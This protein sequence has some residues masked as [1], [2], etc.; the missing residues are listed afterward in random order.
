MVNLAV[1]EIAE[2]ECED[3]SGADA[4]RPQED[5]TEEDA[6]AAKALQR[7]GRGRQH[8]MGQIAAFGSAPA[9]L[10]RLRRARL[11]ALSGWSCPPSGGSSHK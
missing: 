11:A 1:K 4:R 2:E 10:L 3:A 7:M 6:G 9:Q 5:P 8:S